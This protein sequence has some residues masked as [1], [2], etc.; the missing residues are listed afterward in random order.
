MTISCRVNF[1]NSAGNTFLA[2]ADIFRNGE[3]IRTGV[4]PNH[5]L[6]ID[7]ASVVGILVSNISLD[8]DNVEYNCTTRAAPTSFVSS[9]TLNVTGMFI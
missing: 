6:V 7:G 3:V 1:T 2:S 4:P 9:L 5:V 8:D